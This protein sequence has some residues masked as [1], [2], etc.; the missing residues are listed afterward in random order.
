[1]REGWAL[2][3]PRFCRFKGVRRKQQLEYA[4]PNHAHGHKTRIEVPFSN[5]PED[6]FEV[7]EASTQQTLLFPREGEMDSTLMV[8]QGTRVERRTVFGVVLSRLL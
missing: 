5:A 4:P 6:S 1:M 3:S 7:S 2:K 8:N